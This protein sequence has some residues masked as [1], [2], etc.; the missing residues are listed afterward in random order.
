MSNTADEI[1]LVGIFTRLVLTIKNNLVAIVVAIFIGSGLGFGFYQI[2]P[3]VYES[4]L[5]ITSN[6]LTEPVSKSVFANI[7]KLINQ[8]NKTEVSELLHLSPSEISAIQS[9]ELE[10]TIEKGDNLTGGDKTYFNIKVK[11]VDNA[12][13][14]KLQIG[15]ITF[16]EKTD[17]V[18]IRVEQRKKYFILLIAKLDQE[19][20]DLEL[21]KSKIMDGTFSGSKDGMVLLDPSMINSKIIDLNKEKLTYQ[22]SLE[23]VNSVEVIQSFT[24]FANPASPNF[25]LSLAAGAALG[26]FSFFVFLG[27]KS[28]QKLLRKAEEKTKEV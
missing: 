19:L 8:G 12:I 27:H 24:T 9:I 28:L 22:N 10:G 4:E 15:I 20:S 5:I 1:D 3:N 21:L 26:I 16:I 23:L 17:F 6:I 14:P 11:S 13:W 7:Q 18:K 2:S 25:L